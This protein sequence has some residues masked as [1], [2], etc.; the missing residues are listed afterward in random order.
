MPTGCNCFTIASDKILA[1]SKNQAILCAYRAPTAEFGAAAPAICLL[2]D[3]TMNTPVSPAWAVAIIASRE[4]VETLASTVQAALAAA[5]P[6]AVIDVLVNGNPG[7]ARQFAEWSTSVPGAD[8]LRVW[9]IP[10]GDK[11][12]AL[13]EYIHRIWPDG[14][15]AFFLDGYARPRP[16]GLARLA[17]SLASAPEA[18][19]ASGVPS[20]GRSA[21][22][23]RTEMLRTNGF[24]G[25]MHAIPVHAMRALR[26]LGFRLPLGLYRTDS[27]VGAV[28]KFGL[29]PARHGWEQQRI[30]VD[31]DATWDVPG[32]SDLT[33]KNI[34]AQFKRRLRQAQGD[35]ENRAVRDHLALRGLPINRLPKTASELVL[36]W[37]NAHPAEARQ[38]YLKNPLR[39]S[40]VLKAR[41]PKDWSATEDVPELIHNIRT[42]Q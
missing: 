24:H 2:N 41:A 7:L 36:Q 28:L 13:N 12:H 22:A 20:S 32:Q 14:R 40:A 30:V 23:L 5:A 25:N 15:L 26:E 4:S 27:L 33:F 3:F 8:R 17:A 9:S 35:L 38:L 29:D 11:A 18:F 37:I 42:A 31:A 21:P 39:F 6:D 19:G 16:D 1:F 34:K 10:Q